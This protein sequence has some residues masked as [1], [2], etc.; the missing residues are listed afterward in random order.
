MCF[1]VYFLQVVVPM[2]GSILSALGVKMIVPTAGNAGAQL[3]VVAGGA[4]GAGA[5]VDAGEEGEM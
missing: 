1:L 4:G 5:P 3:A 2:V